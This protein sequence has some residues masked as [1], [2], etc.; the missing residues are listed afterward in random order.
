MGL[1]LAAQV[2]AREVKE[3]LFQIAVGRI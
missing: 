1:Q 2:A 3:Y